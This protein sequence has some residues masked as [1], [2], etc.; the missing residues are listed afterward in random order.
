MTKDEQDVE[1]ALKQ[2]LGEELE[3]ATEFEQALDQ[4]DLAR[5]KELLDLV[6]GDALQIQIMRAILNRWEGA[7]SD[8]SHE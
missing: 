6:G 7:R 5:A 2:L 8:E 3:V 4:G 1:N